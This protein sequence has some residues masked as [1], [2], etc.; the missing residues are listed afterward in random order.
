MRPKKIAYVVVLLLLLPVVAIASPYEASGTVIEVLDGNTFAVRIEKFDPRI[1]QDV[2]RVTL[3][4]LEV[5]DEATMIVESIVESM[6][7]SIDESIDESINGSIDESMNGSIDESMNG[8]IDESMNGSIDES[9]ND[10]AAAILLNKTVWLDIDDGSEDGRNS[11]GELIAVL[12][13]SGLDGRPVTSPSFNRMLVD[14]KIARLNDSDANEFDPADW[15]PQE[16]ISIEYISA[17]EGSGVEED[18][19]AKTTGLNIDIN[20]TK[21]NVNVDISRPNI[22]INPTK[23]KVNVNLTGPKVNINPAKPSI[24]V[25]PSKPVIDVNPTTT[26][27]NATENETSEALSSETVPGTSGAAALPFA[28]SDEPLVL[29]NST[30]PITLINPTG[31]ITLINSTGQVTLIDPAKPVKVINSTEIPKMEDINDWIQATILTDPQRAANLS[32]DEPVTNSTELVM[33][34]KSNDTEASD[35]FVEAAA[36]AI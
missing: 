8:S 6:N 23:P 21:P 7:E 2:E 34:A 3:A 4:D 17:E 12:Y 32:R 26:E 33:V 11:E 31:S 18:A 29:S 30:V 13:L 1:K 16:N 27:P 35:I 10:L 15:W 22:A 14:Y 25:N 19:G 9:M 20:P 5:L 28:D 36:E 24:N